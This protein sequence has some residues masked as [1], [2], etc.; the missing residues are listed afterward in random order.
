MGKTIENISTPQIEEASSQSMH[1]V[2]KEV[3]AKHSGDLGLDEEL[4]GQTR[5]TVLE[6]YNISSEPIL[7]P[8]R[9]P[10]KE[11]RKIRAFTI[12]Q[13]KERPEDSYYAEGHTDHA[14]LFNLILDRHSDK[15]GS[16]DRKDLPEDFFDRWTVRKG[17]I[18]PSEEGFTNFPEVRKALLSQVKKHLEINNFS[19]PELEAIAQD[20]VPNWFLSSDSSTE[21]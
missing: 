5:R 20:H 16:D 11:Q 9:Q 4:I 10:A 21:S 18:S 1:A 3:H 14:N 12:I 13:N 19:E 17:F 15:I 6:K 8:E 2:Y 7:F